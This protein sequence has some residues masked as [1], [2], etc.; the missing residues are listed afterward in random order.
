MIKASE[1][2]VWNAVEYKWFENPSF[3]KTL[4]HRENIKI[5]AIDYI[6]KRCLIK[7][8]QR[9]NNHTWVSLERINPIPLTEEILLKCGF[10]KLGKYTFVCDSALMQLEIDVFTDKL[11]HSILAIEVKHLQQLQNL[12][13]ALT[14]EELEINL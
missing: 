2:R 1:L 13:H 3:R 10:E 4:I 9:R 11:V 8:K 7:P 12:Y 14:G 6:N 5:L